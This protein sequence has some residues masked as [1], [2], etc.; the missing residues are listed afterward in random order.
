MGKKTDK[1]SSSGG[2]KPLGSVHACGFCR[3]KTTKAARKQAH[4]SLWGVPSKVTFPTF[5]RSRVRVSLKK[6]G[7]AAD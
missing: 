4:S 5:P 6:T 1:T 7:V 2:L 3:P